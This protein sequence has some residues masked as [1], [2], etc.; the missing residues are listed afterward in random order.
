VSAQAYP[1]WWIERVR[2][3]MPEQWEA[4]LAAGNQRPP[5]A[6]RVNRMRR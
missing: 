1:A 2:A 6:L 3:G 4:L 5:M